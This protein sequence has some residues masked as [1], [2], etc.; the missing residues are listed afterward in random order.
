MK[1]D[2]WGNTGADGTN[3]VRNCDVG[4]W[5]RSTWFRIGTG[6]GHL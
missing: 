1:R 4:I 3:I 5:T 6:V 2:H